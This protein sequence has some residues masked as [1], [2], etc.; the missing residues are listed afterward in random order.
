MKKLKILF[1]FL[2]ICML[3]GCSLDDPKYLHFSNKKDPAFYTKEVYSRILNNEQF[4]MILFNTNLYKDISIDSSE[5]D[6]I[7]NFIS[8]LTDKDYESQELP[9]K[10]EIYELRLEF[11]DGSKYIINVYNN[12]L[13]TLHPWDG[14][15][16]E[17][18]I[19]MEEVPV[20]YNLFD[21]C[22][23]IENQNKALK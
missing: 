16:P 22:T 7:K 15:Y 13:A 5:N 19:S 17:D 8:S 18:I 21:F 14:N 6:I 1:I 10:T 9:N 23:H 3:Q 20:H 2:I 4:K 11:S 12:N